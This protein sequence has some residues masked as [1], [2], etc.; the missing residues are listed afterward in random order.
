MSKAHIPYPSYPR[1]DFRVAVLN[2]RPYH[3]GVV[4]LW[5]VGR[6]HLLEWGGAEYGVKENF[7]GNPGRRCGEGSPG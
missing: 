5:K 1:Y 7:P 3:D 4:R 2:L 6:Y